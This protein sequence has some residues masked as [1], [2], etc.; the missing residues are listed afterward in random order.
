MEQPPFNILFDGT[1]KRV[2]VART[3]LMAKN[4]AENHRLTNQNAQ[5]DIGSNILQRTPGG[6]DNTILLTDLQKIQ[7]NRAENG[8]FTDD[9]DKDGLTDGKE[10]NGYKPV[11]ITGFVE[12]LLTA[13][14]G[15]PNVSTLLENY[16]AHIIEAN[17]G[18]LWMKKR[19]IVEA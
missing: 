16:K 7:L 6:N 12:H 3:Y 1:L 9:A 10:L 4:I 2:Y 13:E 11:D 19:N 17:K 5:Y 8:A 18:F 14:S 15:L